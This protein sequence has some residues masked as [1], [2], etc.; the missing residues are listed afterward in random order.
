[1]HVMANMS[2]TKIRRQQSGNRNGR[3]AHDLGLG[4]VYR[5]INDAVNTK[6]QKIDATI[7]DT[8]PKGLAYY[9]SM[10]FSSDKSE[11]GKTIKY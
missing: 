8:N 7:G 10:G 9:E 6:L 3:F 5:L 2:R 4:I 1:M 11:N